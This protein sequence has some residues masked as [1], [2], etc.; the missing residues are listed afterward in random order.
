MIENRIVVVVGKS[1]NLDR[2]LDLLWTEDL[3][4]RVIPTVTEAG[5][6]LLG[7]DRP[8][9]RA[10]L[11]S[12]VEDPE[13]AVELVRS[14]RNGSSLSSVPIVVWAR[15]A[16]DGALESAY[17]AGADSGVLLD[18]GSEDPV[19]VARTIRWWAGRNTSEGAWRAPDARA[20][21]AE[22]HVAGVGATGLGSPLP[23]PV[24]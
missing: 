1:R 19:R 14:L 4:V 13:G 20:G 8:L 10:V 24:S 23:P 18:G 11:V 21:D 12:L 9:V 3:R 6:A 5:Y 17:R 2:A 22:P 7:C 16:F 15:E